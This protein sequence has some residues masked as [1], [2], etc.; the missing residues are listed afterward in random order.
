MSSINGIGGIGASLTASTQ[1]A[2]LQ[3]SAGETTSFKN[4]LEKAQAKQ[5][6]KALME[7][8]EQF[9]SI[10]V[11]MMF[12]TMKAAN[13]EEDDEDAFIQKSFG[14]G[15]FEDM[16]DDEISK[17]VASAGGI[18]IAKVMY[19]QLKKYSDPVE[20]IAESIIDTKK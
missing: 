20:S 8:C 1:T 5:D 9:E 2:E 4:A 7:V 3:K 14:R 15:I 13:T 16:K 12:D 19:N 6:D 11:K 17:K 10:F 18:G